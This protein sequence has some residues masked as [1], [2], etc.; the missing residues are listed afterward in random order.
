MRQSLVRPIGYGAML[1]EGLVGIVALIAAAS[2]DPKL[3][4]EINV[5]QDTKT[6]EKWQP[7]ID[8]MIAEL[9]D[10]NIVH[11]PVERT[12]LQWSNWPDVSK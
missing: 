3:Y 7:K 8:H 1:M 12:D 4:Y 6:L 10:A 5:S 9:G 11:L 2:M